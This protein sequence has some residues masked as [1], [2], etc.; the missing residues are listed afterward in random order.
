MVS[1]CVY[2]TTIAYRIVKDQRSSKFDLKSDFRTNAVLFFFFML[3][4]VLYIFFSRNVLSDGH[5]GRQSFFPIVFLISCFD[6]MRGIEMDCSLNESYTYNGSISFVSHIYFN[7]TYDMMEKPEKKISP[8]VSLETVSI[9]LIPFLERRWNTY[10]F[11]IQLSII[12]CS[13]IKYVN[14]YLTSIF[15]F[16]FLILFLW[17]YIFFK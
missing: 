1:R 15:F 16:F 4:Y 11:E 9:L 5:R 10:I 8:R 7:T 13:F 6:K 2:T 3:L 12:T 14:K 17:I